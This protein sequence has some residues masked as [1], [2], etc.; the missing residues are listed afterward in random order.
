MVGILPIVFG[1]MLA[2]IMISYV[3]AHDA[4][5]ETFRITGHDNTVCINP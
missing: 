3:G 2:I 4:E 1:F 5:Q